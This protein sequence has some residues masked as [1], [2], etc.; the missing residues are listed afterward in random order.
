MVTHVALCFR[1]GNSPL[2]CGHAK[3]GNVEHVGFAGEV[4]TF[5]SGVPVNQRHEIGS[6]GIGVKIVV[7]LGEQAADIP[8]QRFLP[9][10]LQPL[11]FL[12]EV[13]LKRRAEPIAKLDGD[14]FVGISAPIPPSLCDNANGVCL[15]QP[16]FNCEPESVARQVQSNPVISD[17]IKTGVVQQLPSA[18]KLDRITKP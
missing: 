4:E 10:C 16:S 13:N 15:L 9:F 18:E 11:E 3:N 5:P 12:D 17:R 1:V 7:D 2:L 14:V 6:D 8:V